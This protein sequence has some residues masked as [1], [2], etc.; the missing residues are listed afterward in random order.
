MITVHAY[1]KNLL[2]MVVK[3]VA[4]KHMRLATL[5]KQFIIITNLLLFAACSTIDEDMSDCGC[6]LRA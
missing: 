4:C 3:T 6:E 5:A 2:A 1:I